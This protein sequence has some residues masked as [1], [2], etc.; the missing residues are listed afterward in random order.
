MLGM[1]VGA[2]IGRVLPSI[3]AAALV[4]ALAFT[5]LSFAQ[6]RWQETLVEIHRMNYVDPSASLDS[7]ALVTNTGL[8]LS[9]GEV[10]TWPELN[11][12][13][14][15]VTYVDEQ[16]RLFGSEQ[17]MQDGN[18]LGYDVEFAIPGSRY[19]AVVGVVGAASVGV[20]L[21]ALGLTAVVVSRR[22]P[23]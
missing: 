21:V 15:E 3:L 14:L 8:E 5:G 9:G 16:G 2:L 18:V 19:A 23:F 4:M 6:D 11:E 20:G 22:R 10:V 7:G 1:F 17:D 12:R 13:G